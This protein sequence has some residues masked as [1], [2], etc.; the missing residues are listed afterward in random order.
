LES[1]LAGDVEWLEVWHPEK[2]DFKE[3]ARLF[4][5]AKLFLRA[6]YEESL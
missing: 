5:Q 1:T 4:Y 3:T 6:H 2:F